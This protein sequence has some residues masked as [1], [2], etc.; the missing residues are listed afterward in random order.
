MRSITRRQVQ[1][2][3]AAER[4]AA[5]PHPYTFRNAHGHLCLRGAGE[6]TYAEM[7]RIIASARAQAAKTEKDNR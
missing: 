5:T 1:L 2:L 7:T 4:R 3:A 6:I